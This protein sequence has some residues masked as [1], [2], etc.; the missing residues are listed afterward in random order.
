MDQLSRLILVSKTQ[1]SAGKSR[2]FRIAPLTEYQQ[3]LYEA[4]GGAS[5][6]LSLS[7]I[8]TTS[9]R[10]KISLTRRLIF[11]FQNRSWRLRW[12]E[13]GVVGKAAL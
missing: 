7:R 13:H 5:S 9:N 4:P 10:R 2:D 12:Y 8:R 6:S 11:F 3:H 1:F